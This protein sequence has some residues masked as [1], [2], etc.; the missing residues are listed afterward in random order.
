M[1]CFIYH[2]IQPLSQLRKDVFHNNV[3]WIMCTPD[4]KMSL[5]YI[6][7]NSKLNDVLWFSHSSK[8]DKDNHFNAMDSQHITSI[9]L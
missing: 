8:L 5:V 9:K 6:S 3:C 2:I 1:I 7:I 4:W